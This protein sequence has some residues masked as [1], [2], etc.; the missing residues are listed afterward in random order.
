M[1]SDLD[2]FQALLKSATKPVF[3]K[4]GADW[5][6]PCRA[7][8]PA[9]HK[10]SEEFSTKAVFVTVDVDESP[11]IASHCEVRSIPVVKVFVKGAAV[12][13]LKPAREDGLRKLLAK[14]CL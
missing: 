2:A 12:E 11:D 13:E 8:D 6:N 10:I 5:C 1:S 14:Y 9:F 3:V 7:F 4:Y